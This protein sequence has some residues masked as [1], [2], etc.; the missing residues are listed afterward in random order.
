MPQGSELSHREGGLDLP[1]PRSQGML[2]SQPAPWAK[3]PVM[4][5]LASWP[6]GGHCHIL[7]RCDRRGKGRGS[8]R[9]EPGLGKGDPAS[10]T[11][12]CASPAPSPGLSFPI[13]TQEGAVKHN[14]KEVWF[15]PVWVLL[16]AP[17]FNSW[18]ALGE[19]LHLSKLQLPSLEEEDNSC[20]DRVFGW[21]PR[22]RP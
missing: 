20:P 12:L 13:W 22:S 6:S 3:L 7:M 19:S 18:V 11:D 4:L 5:S 21:G 15:I 8:C 1:F 10:A 9:E 14:R 16:P 2:I 17:P